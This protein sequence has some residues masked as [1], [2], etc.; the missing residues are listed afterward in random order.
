MRKGILACVLVVLFSCSKENNKLIV[1]NSQSEKYSEIEK[2]TIVGYFG[3][4]EN[5]KYRDSHLSIYGHN[6]VAESIINYIK[7]NKLLK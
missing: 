5:A 3:H 2:R 7:E 4:P 1:V 6:V